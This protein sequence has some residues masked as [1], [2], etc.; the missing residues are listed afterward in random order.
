MYFPEYWSPRDLAAYPERASP[1]YLT[2]VQQ[3]LR[4][5]RHIKKKRG[6]TRR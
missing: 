6:K 2:Y 4:R 5:K 3:I 1:D